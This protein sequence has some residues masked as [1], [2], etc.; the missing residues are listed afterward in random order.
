MVRELTGVPLGIAQAAVPGEPKTSSSAV[1]G[2]PLDQLVPVFQ[3]LLLVLVQVLVTAKERDE[4]AHTAKTMAARR[5]S[6]LFRAGLIPD[7]L[8]GRRGR[9]NDAGSNLGHVPW[10][11]P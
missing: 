11:R 6:L 8:A 3:R 9:V 4:T 7:I 10:I 2:T 1:V 5:E